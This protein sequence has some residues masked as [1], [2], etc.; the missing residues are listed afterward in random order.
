MNKSNQHDLQ[1]SE[2]RIPL[3]SIVT[4]A[5]NEAENLPFLYKRLS[6]VLNIPELTWEWIIVD[7]HSKDDTFAVITELT[8]QDSRIRGIR[9]ARNFG[10]PTALTCGLHYAKGDCAINIAADL[11]DPPETLPELVTCWQK[12][13][14]VVWAVRHQ[15]YGEKVSKVWFARLYY[16]LMRH[17]VGL[18]EMPATGADFFLIDRKVIEALQQFN[19]THVSI[20]AL[21]IW[22]GFRQT[23]IT[24]D[25]QARLHGQSGWNLEKKLKL[26][27]D[28]VTSFTYLPIRLMSYTGLVVALLGFIYA[29]AIIVSALIGSNPVQGWSSLM[30]VI[31]VLGGMQMLMMGMLGEY[32][33][34]TLDESRRRPRYLIED[35]INISSFEYHRSS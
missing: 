14:Q 3:L 8:K 19:E 4:T 27:L 13:A 30:V 34:R 25:K 2:N 35:T 32:L 11:Q 31:L 18:K 20:L 26:V 15:R 5:Y 12:G 28:S 33:W 24:Y 17:V 1:P 9:F 23:Y 16:F 10:S 29:G 7:D 21:I 22:M 6:Q